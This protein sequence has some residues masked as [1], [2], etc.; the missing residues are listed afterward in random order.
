MIP[1]RS[2]RSD[3]LTGGCASDAGEFVEEGLK[4]KKADT[5]H[6]RANRHFIFWQEKPVL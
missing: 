1:Q 5:P 4:N 6:S 2:R 3:L